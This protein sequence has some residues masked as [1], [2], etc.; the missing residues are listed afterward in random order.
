MTGR[1]IIE[2]ALAVA[3]KGDP[4]EAPFPLSPD[5]AAIWHQAQAS[6]YQHAL[7]MMEGD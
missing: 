2:R 6:A 5:E 1:E 3:L 4:N 7:E